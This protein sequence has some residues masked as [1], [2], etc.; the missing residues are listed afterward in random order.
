V[1]PEANL[2]KTDTGLVPAT[3]GWF[4]VNARDARWNARPGRQSVS[5]T[6]K[7]EWDADTYFPMLGVNLAVIDPG[8]PN[9]M[10]HWETEAEA[11]LVLSGEALLIVEGQERPLRQW[12]F[13]HLPP[14]TEHVVVGAGDGPCV[15]LAMSSREN[16]QFGPYGEYVANEV[17]RR[18]GASPEETTQDGEEAD[19]GWPESQPS[20]Y[21]EGWLPG[22]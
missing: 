12:D 2:T 11:F 10:Y 9:S 14:K 22:D 16:Q 18:Y 15:V 20:R 21:R 8:E 13:V 3:P 19:A 5:F 4:V 1:V 6:G 17:A 7:T